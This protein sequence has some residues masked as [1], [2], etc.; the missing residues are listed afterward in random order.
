MISWDLKVG[1]D[2]QLISI[3]SGLHKLQFLNIAGCHDITDAGIT[4]VARGLPQL[5]SLDISY[6]G[7][8]T[9]EG[10]E[11]AKRICKRRQS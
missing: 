8:I 10:G 6:C 5:Q 3:A 7:K 2:A 1:S 11:N 4:A 9:A